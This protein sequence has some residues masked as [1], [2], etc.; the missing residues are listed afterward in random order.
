MR[1]RAVLLFLMLLCA[2]AGT[3]TPRGAAIPRGD[4]VPRVSQNFD[5]CDGESDASSAGSAPVCD[6]FTECDI[7]RGNLILNGTQT[8][9]QV[10]RQR[11]LPSGQAGG[12]LSKACG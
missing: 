5:A 3:S 6:P 8:C 2:I 12:R 4:T 9:P 1:R 11:Q 10:D 7:D